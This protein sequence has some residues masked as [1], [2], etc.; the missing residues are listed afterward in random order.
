[1]NVEQ[2][3]IP[4][5]SIA[6]SQIARELRHDAIERISTIVNNVSIP[7]EEDPKQVQQKDA[8][9]FTD[10][11]LDLP[12]REA[13]QTIEHYRKAI[14]HQYTARRQC[15]ELLLKSRC[16]FGSKEAAEEFYSLQDKIK[17]LQQHI[18][19]LQDAMELEGLDFEN[20]KKEED[21]AMDADDNLSMDQ[22]LRNLEPIAWYTRSP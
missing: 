20:V 2:I 7:I 18:L 1:V 5:R 19:L 6:T 11:F 21:D 12:L 17:L 14:Q 4:Y 10:E 13:L 22:R 8:P 15:V 9:Q 3:L 16:Q